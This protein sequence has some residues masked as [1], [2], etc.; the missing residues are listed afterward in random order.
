MKTFFVCLF[1][2]LILLSAVAKSLVPARGDDKKNHLVWVSDPNPARKEQ[3]AQFNEMFPDY[4]LHLDPGNRGAQKIIMQVAAGVGPDVFDSW[5]SNGLQTYVKAGIVA[6]VTDL[7]REMGFEYTK[8]YRGARSSFVYE[9]R[10]YGFPCNAQANVVW[11][12]RAV[13]RRHGVPVPT[14]KDWTWPEFIEV[15]KKTTVP[16]KD[17]RG[18]E[19]YGFAGTWS[20]ETILQFGGRQYSPDG[21]RCTLYSPEAIAG[22]KTCFDLRFDHH[23][24]PT[25]AE[26]QSMSGVGGWGQG[27]I[28]MFANGRYAMMRG[29][30]W[31]LITFRQYYTVAPGEDREPLEITALPMPRAPGRDPLVLAGARCAL[32]NADARNLRDACMFLKYLASE[33]YNRELNRFA[34]GMP[35]LASFTRT[36]DFLVNKNYPQEDFHQIFRAVME[37]TVSGE[38]SPFVDGSEANRIFY[39][40]IDRCLAKLAEA[41]HP[42]TGQVA[43]EALK[44]AAEKINAAIR[45]NISRNKALKMKYDAVTARKTSAQ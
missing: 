32:V 16:R 14:E 27:H 39:Y 4:E 43:A 23:V 15:A 17:G 9:G 8:T 18:Y 25:P 40:E 10:Q 21:T 35:P 26:E 31:M 29:G 38:T 24:Q 36:E 37:H 1:A 44:N 3:I 5:G 12:N 33:R 6:D 11:I 20:K 34:D 7:A 13:F 19:C 30:R 45:R 41:D 22:L 42:P 28:N 2:G